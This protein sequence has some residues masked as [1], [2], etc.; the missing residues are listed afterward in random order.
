MRTR[1]F[2]TFRG[3]PWISGAEAIRIVDNRAPDPTPP[4]MRPKKEASSLITSFTSE[5]NVT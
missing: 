5:E 1:A 2:R 3:K 4:R